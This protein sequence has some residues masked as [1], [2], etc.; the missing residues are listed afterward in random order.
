MVLIA[1]EW[2]LIQTLLDLAFNKPA[3]QV[4][5]AWGGVASRAVD[6][7]TTTGYSQG[8]CTHTDWANNAWWRVDLGSSLPV[9]EVV[10]VNRDCGGECATFMSSFEIWIGKAYLLTSRAQLSI[11][12]KQTYRV[13]P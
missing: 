5:T 12:S 3:Q 8:S 11:M 13:L 2:I 9:A 1:S 10:I 6:G 7:I 4:S